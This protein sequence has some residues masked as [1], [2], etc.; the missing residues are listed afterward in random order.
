MSFILDALRKSDAERQRS[1]TPGLADARYAGR[2]TARS[3]WMPVLIVV[4]VANMLFMGAD[5]F[6][7]SRTAPAV[8]TEGVAGGV[9]E[10]GTPGPPPLVRPLAR[11]TS[12]AGSFFEPPME[13]DLPPEPGA[14][15]PSPQPAAPLAGTSAGSASP[16][17]VAAPRDLPSSAPTLVPAFVAADPALPASNPSRILEG[18]DLPTFEK[19]LGAGM[20]E[21]PMLNLDL[22]V[23]SSQ[24]A[25]RFVVI[26]SRKYNEGG[27]LTEGPQVEAITPDGV[28]LTSGGQRFTLARK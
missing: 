8:S 16:G 10:V 22:H 14:V 9:P 3:W 28:I 11:E 7:R 5:W 12:Q 23:Y 13:F 18:N 1:V 2:R 4:L 15:A 25:G 17:G 27:Q 21:I 19:L 24:A 20:L 6:Q 26:N